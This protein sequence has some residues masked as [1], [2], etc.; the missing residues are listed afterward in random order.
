MTSVAYNNLSKC[1]SCSKSTYAMIGAVNG[2]SFD[3][4]SFVTVMYSWNNRDH[5]EF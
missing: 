3:C 1:A 5:C 4:N 2:G